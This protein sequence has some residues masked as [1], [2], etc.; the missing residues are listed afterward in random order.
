MLCSIITPYTVMIKPD[1]F[2]VAI[3]ICTFV[4]LVA[5]SSEAPS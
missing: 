4:A 5:S 1:G 3:I 2:E